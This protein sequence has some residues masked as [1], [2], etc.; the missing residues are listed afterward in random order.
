MNTFILYAT[1]GVIIF[2][3]G[4][5]ALISYANLIRKAL[6]V[7][8]MSV[9]VFIFLIAA[10]NRNPE[11][12]P[13][14]VPYALVLTGIVV[15]VSATAFMLAII[16]RIYAITGCTELESISNAEQEP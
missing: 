16:F 5:H 9:G 10:A 12:I 6:A 1:T 4:L 11:G 3:I 14:P 13:D 8:V 2:I 15:A 7:N